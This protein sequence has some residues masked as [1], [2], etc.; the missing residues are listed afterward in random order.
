MSTSRPPAPPSLTERDKTATGFSRH[1]D[2]LLGQVPEALCAIFIDSEGEAID[3]ASCIDLFDA[4]IAGAEMAVALSSARTM[5][6][7]LRQGDSVEVRIEGTRRSIIARHVAEECHLVV[8]VSTPSISAHVAE[9]TAMTAL[10][11]LT[12]SGLKPPAAAYLVLRSVEQRPNRTGMPVP[13][14]FEGHGVRHKVEAVLGHRN[15]GAE[16]RFLV[17]LDNGEELVM[18]HDRV[19]GGWKRGS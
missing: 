11:I 17:R 5:S 10:A 4:R 7:K 19:N 8:M 1:L 9:A 18:V 3:L 15:E 14:S 16:V 12:E 13:S 6:Q 2:T